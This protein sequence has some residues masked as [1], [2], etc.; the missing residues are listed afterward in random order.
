MS[1]SRSPAPGSANRS[2]AGRPASRS[3]ARRHSPWQLA[4]GQAPGAGTPRA[5]A[6]DERAKHSPDAQPQQPTARI[7]GRAEM[8]PEQSRCH[9][10][11]T[12]REPGQVT[13]LPRRSPER[14]RLH[15]PMLGPTC[16]MCGYERVITT[17]RPQR[18]TRSQGQ[19]LG[20]EPAYDGVGEW[21]VEI[22]SVGPHPGLHRDVPLL[23]G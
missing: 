22:R 15:A 12:G 6:A 19:S 13:N 10:R 18:S 4:R 3:R 17:Q 21:Y 14:H 7:A 23:G 16:P 20:G 5:P 8:N 11:R 1:D 2:G 9:G